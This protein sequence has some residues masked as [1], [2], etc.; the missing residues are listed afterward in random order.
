MFIFRRIIRDDIQYKLITGNNAFD[1]IAPKGS[2]EQYIKVDSISGGKY[3]TYLLLEKNELTNLL[4]GLLRYRISTK[5]E[6]IDQINTINIPEN[7]Q[8]NINSLLAL[9]KYDIIYLSRIGV[10]QEFHEIRIS[11]IISNFFEFLIQRK[12][13]NII[14]FTKVLENLTSVVGSKY[15]I[16]GKGTDETWGNYFLMNKIIEYNP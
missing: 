3:L 13:K 7:I 14:I 4:L 1:K 15:R 11:Q 2:L 12:R 16:L 9:N 10:S 8:S 5:N 6:F